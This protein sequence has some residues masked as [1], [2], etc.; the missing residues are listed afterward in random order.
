MSTPSSSSVRDSFRP[1]GRAGRGAPVE[2]AKDVKHTLPRLCA[3]FLP[4][5]KY[6][7]LLALAVVLAVVANVAAPGL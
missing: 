7:I 4:D 3:F 1:G 6:V 2:K 5:L